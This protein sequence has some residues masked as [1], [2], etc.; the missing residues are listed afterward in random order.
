MSPFHPCQYEILSNLFKFSPMNKLPSTNYHVA[1]TSRAETMTVLSVLLALGLRW[2]SSRPKTPAEIVAEAPDWP[3]VVAENDQREIGLGRSTPPPAHWARRAGQRL[4]FAEFCTAL[5]VRAGDRLLAPDEITKDGDNYL[6]VGYRRHGYDGIGSCERL[7]VPASVARDSI[8]RALPFSSPADI[9]GIV[10]KIEPVIIPTPRPRP[11]ATFVPMKFDAPSASQP[12][13]QSAIDKDTAATLIDAYQSDRFGTLEGLV[14]SAIHAER[15]ACIAPFER[16][17]SDGGTEVFL[18]AAAGHSYEDQKWPK[19]RGA[20]NVL[21]AR[22][23]CQ[24]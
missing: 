2:T 3:T 10:R 5:G 24:S 17:F 16:R 7:G 8:V 9:P 1:C 23:R 6:S 20:L 18:S 22:L 12:K 19:T 13:A 11:V 14:L 4:T 21:E 15:K